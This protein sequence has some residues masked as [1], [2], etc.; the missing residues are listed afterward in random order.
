M[1]PDDVLRD[2]QALRDEFD[3]PQS[4]HAD[5]F[6]RLAAEHGSEVYRRGASRIQYATAL[7]GFLRDHTDAVHLFKQRASLCAALAIPVTIA[8]SK[9]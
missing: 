5:V 7:A 8:A 3:S 9:G 4:V 2:Q 6:A 1:K